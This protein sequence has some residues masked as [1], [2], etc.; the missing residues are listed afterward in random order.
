M[1][2]LGLLVSFTADAGTES[3]IGASPVALIDARTVPALPPGTTLIGAERA[4]DGAA[5]LIA[6]VRGGRI[7]AEEP[8][9]DELKPNARTFP[10]VR[11]EGK[12]D[13]L[14]PPA[15]SFARSAERLREGGAPTFA[16]LT[17]SVSG[18]LTPGPATWTPD[19]DSEQGFQPVPDLGL[20][21]HGLVTAE[22]EIAEP[23]DLGDGA[24]PAIPRAVAL[25]ST[26]PAPAD[27]IPIEVAAASLALPGFSAREAPSAAGVPLDSRHRYA[28]L[29]EPDSMDREQR[30]LAEAVY[31][32]ARSEP[33]DGQ[34]AVAQ[35]VLNRVKSGLYPQSVCGVVYQNRHRYMACQFSFACEGKSLRITDAAS[36]QS[37]TRIAKAVIEGRTYLSEVGGATHYH[38]DY[39]K[40]RWSRRLLKMDVIGRHIFYSLKRGQT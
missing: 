13:A 26:T 35:V 8:L 18:V 24:T 12:G 11:R 2:G 7:L 27:A 4:G 1:A 16:N 38:A 34:A 6:S 19:L 29:I 33:E 39:V 5:T 15:A 9:R 36:W 3:S 21:P 25:G 17:G 10:I 37:A 32:E 14:V 23:E 20:S 30:C 28:D 22:A 40:P 31:F